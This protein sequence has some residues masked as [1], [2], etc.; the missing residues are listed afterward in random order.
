MGVANKRE[1]RREQKKKRTQEQRGKSKNKSKR[2][3]KK[4]RKRIG[5]KRKDRKIGTQNRRCHQILIKKKE[6]KENKQGQKEI[7][8][9][10]RQMSLTEREQIE[11]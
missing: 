5:G 8:R 10:I 3:H 7:A 4:K 2:K 9:S 1:E 11:Q 6:Y